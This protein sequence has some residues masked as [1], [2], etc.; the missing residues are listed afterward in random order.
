MNKLQL[1]PP[2]F[3]IKNAEL[4]L[5]RAIMGGFLPFSFLILNC[6]SALAQANPNPPERLTYQGFLAD[7][8]GTALGTNAPK[9]YDVVFR[10]WDDASATAPANRLWTEQQTVTVDK[11]FFSVLLGEGTQVTSPA[12]EPHGALSTLFTNAT[13]SDRFVEMTVK[14]IGAAGADVKILP[15]L[16]LLTSPYA[17]L[18]T[19]AISANSASSVDGSAVTGT[20]LDAR[21]SPNVAL[22]NRNSQ[23]FT[24]NNTFAGNVGI[25]TTNPAAKLHVAG[26]GWFGVDGNAL[27]SAAGVGV[28]VYYDNQISSGVVNCHDY[29]NNVP[30]NLALGIT[31]GNVGIGTTAP[32]N[33]LTVSGNADF[34]GNVGIGTTTPQTPLHVAGI[35]GIAL[36]VNY[37][38]GSYTALQ[39]SL[40]SVSDGYAKIQAIKRSGLDLGN[41]ILNPEGG[42]VGIGTTT[43][44][45]AK[46]EVNGFT[47]FT[48][49]GYNWAAGGNNGS[50]TGAKN[51]SVYASGLIGAVTFTAYSDERIKHIEGQSNGFRDLVTL[52]G[53]EV[54]DYTYI[55]T[56]TKSAGK[57]KKV[58]AQQVEK[59]YPQAVS[60]GT[61]VVPDIYQK[62]EF[63]DGWVKA[64]TSLK[65]GERVRLI[66]EKEEAIHEVLEVRDGA[67]RTAF[68]PATNEVFVYGR[69]VKDFRSVDYEAISMLNVSATQE[70]ARRLEKVEARESHVAELERKAGRV[71]TLEQEVADLKKLVAQLAADSKSAKLA[72]QATKQTH[73]AA[74]A[75]AEKAFTTASL[76]R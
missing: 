51:F 39:M 38:T 76:V 50:D 36:G 30:K 31:G 1:L 67:F 66:G 44:T 25:G 23:A 35:N 70:L 12:T 5:W 71:E 68:Q 9:N 2:P 6:I 22:L 32:S 62:A 20:V 61:D 19:K 16:R 72:A 3:T 63:M 11:G 74:N 33:K 65:V 13:A 7:G 4:K 46:L 54:T 10:L 75:T 43:P 69:E 52:S 24:G 41:L 58:I 45:K 28:R 60:R 14:G 18:A 17:Y 57:Q 15:R 73:A 55:D 21:L 48:L 27:P 42:N 59:V 49:A 64:A 29:A 26:S 56:V 8:T 40:S 34:T 47:S 37:A 53:I